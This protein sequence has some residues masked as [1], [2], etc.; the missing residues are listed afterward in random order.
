MRGTYFYAQLEMNTVQNQFRRELYRGPKTRQAFTATDSF[1]KILFNGYIA[2]SYACIYICIHITMRTHLVL[3]A[4][5]RIP[6]APCLSADPLMF[7]KTNT[8]VRIV[9]HS[10]RWHFVSVTP[11]LG[12]H[13]PRYHLP[14]RWS[15]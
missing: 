14:P 3:V 11:W 6:Y 7:I 1:S 10:L 9:D 4:E 12:P 13:T 8:R 2:K 5:K 15:E